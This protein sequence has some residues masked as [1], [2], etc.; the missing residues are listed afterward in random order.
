MSS[1]ILKLPSSVIDQIVAGKV[2]ENPASIVRELIENSLDAGAKTIS[3]EIDGGGLDRVRVEDDG[4]G[5]S[6]EDAPLSL[7]RHA[8]SKIRSVDDLQ[9]LATMGFRGEALAAIASISHFEIHTSDGEKATRITGKAG[10]IIAVE[11][12]ARNQGTT[13]EI[14]SLFFNAPARKRFQKSQSACTAAI[15]RTVEILALAHP[16]ISFTFN[17]RIFF[18]SNYRERIFE[19][20]GEHEHEVKGTLLFG[21]VASP[22]KAMATRTG[23]YL[24]I[25]RRPIFSPLIAKAVKEAFGTRISEHAYPRFV[26]FLTIDPADVDVNVHPQKKEV[27]FRD[28]K[29]VFRLVQKAIEGAFSIPFDFPEKVSFHPPLAQSFHDHFAPLP[30]K[31][32]ETHFDWIEPE[33]PLA[34]LGKFFLLQ[35]ET[36]LLI[37]L[38]A[39]HARVLFEKIKF[40][41]CAPQ[42]LLWPLE[43][44]ISPEEEERAIALESLGIECRLMKKSLVIDALPPFLDPS[45]FPQFYSEWKK[46]KK[47]EEIATRYC[48]TIQKTFSL[49]EAFRLWQ[50]VKKCK[51]SQ[52]DP[53]GNPI[54]IQWSEEDLAHMITRGKNG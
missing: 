16:E 6:R 19:I 50:E 52:Y 4:C 48:R 49:D 36:L 12:C 1:K 37:D 24:Y 14:K 39:A 46:G 43:I 15:A 51:D 22:M 27:R 30:F 2:I 17:K 26:L 18:P 33:K 3:I 44:P 40:E 29:S 28:E 53:L 8:T 32:Q 13:I 34:V 11:P 41:Q 38:R 9:T 10:K 7:E 35:K 5:M 45:T 42:A 25:N 21:F 23:Q 47:F 31:V 54:F 20:L